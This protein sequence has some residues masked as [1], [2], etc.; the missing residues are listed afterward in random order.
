MIVPGIDIVD[1]KGA[2]IDRVN[3]V[4]ARQ[5]KAYVFPGLTGIYIFL[6]YISLPYVVI[7]AITLHRHLKVSDQYVKEN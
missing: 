3:D 4:K 1:T 2:D 5:R 6:I 7:Y